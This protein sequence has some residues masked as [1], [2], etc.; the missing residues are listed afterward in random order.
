MYVII[1]QD[2]VLITIQQKTTLFAA[3]L[4]RSDGTGQ[5]YDA[6][7]DVCGK[8]LLYGTVFTS[9][10]SVSLLWREIGLS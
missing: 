1:A 8:S 9:S 3:G 10:F 4:L 5:R 7:S 2:S 6:K